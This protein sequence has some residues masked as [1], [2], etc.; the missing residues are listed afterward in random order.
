MA[1]YY[2][3]D[4]ETTLSTNITMTESGARRVEYETSAVYINKLVKD[5]TFTASVAPTENVRVYYKYEY[6]TRVD[7]GNWSDWFEVNTYVTLLAG[8][9]T[10]TETVKVTEYICYKNED[11]GEEI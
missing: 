4:G 1:T 7:N 8:H 9:T 3:C 11:D 6:T 2:Y 5:L 10:V